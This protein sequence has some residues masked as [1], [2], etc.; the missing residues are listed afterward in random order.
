MVSWYTVNED[1]ERMW[2]LYRPVSGWI[3]SLQSGKTGFYV[4]PSF[5]LTENDTF[6]IIKGPFSFDS[7]TI[8]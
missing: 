6:S 5:L 3:R 2:R 1:D 7:G 8:F 4:L